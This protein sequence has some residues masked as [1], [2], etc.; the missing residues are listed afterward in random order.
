MTRIL[1]HWRIVYI[2]KSRK[3]C[4]FAIYSFFTTNPSLHRWDEIWRGVY[5]S[6]FTPNFTPPVQRVAHAGWKIHNRPLGNPNT[7]VCLE[8]IMPVI[9]TNILHVIIH[10]GLL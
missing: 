2:P 3:I 5:S 6:E 8:G 9:K 10:L 4:S 7:G 1:E